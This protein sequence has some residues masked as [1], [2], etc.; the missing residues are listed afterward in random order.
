MA[1]MEQL[2]MEA[3]RKQ[4]VRDVES[5]VEKYR[6]IFEWDVPEVDE[7]AAN[8]LILAAVRQALDHIEQALPSAPAP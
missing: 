4:L 8:R 5:L 7:G 1:K 2:E 3:H 6:A